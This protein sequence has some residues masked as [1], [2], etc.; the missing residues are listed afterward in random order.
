[1]ADKRIDLTGAKFPTVDGD[2]NEYVSNEA[3]A[4]K[5]FD[6]SRKVVF[7]NGM[8][9]SGENHAESAVTLSLLQMATVIGV[10]NA[11]AG[12][13]KD[14]LQCI[15]DKNQ[16]DGP[17][18]LSA[19]SKV[20]LGGLL[21]RT[22]IN[23]AYAALARNAAQVPL[24]DLLRKRG[25]TQLEIFAH[26]QGNLILS[27][28]LQAIAAVDGPAALSGYTVHTFGSPAVNWPLGLRK[29]EHG[30]T[31]D[32]VAFLAGFDA[33][34]SISKVGLP[35]GLDMHGFLGYMRNDPAFVV[36]R[37]RVGGWGITFKMD[38]A[39]LADALIA[40]GGNI[41]RVSAIFAHLDK[42][43]NSDADDVAEL[44]VN[45]L[46]KSP[47]TAGAIRA[48]GSLVALLIRILDDGWTSA[49]EKAA[50]AFL[51]GT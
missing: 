48:D 15:A 10:Y 1:M 44:Y 28:V 7:I 18:S 50:I 39:G 17:A 12:F 13:G 35:G 36:N 51:R 8:G 43:H 31:F 22:P 3:V 29:F 42:K 34:W 23:V 30:F 16:F 41:R 25:N 46:R 2:I 4:S 24:F 47:A 37:Y 14:F 33:T 19:K 45:R 21:G 38:E 9:N 49:G 5:Q 40:M 26:S 11:S 32:Y 27:N 6:K 20:A